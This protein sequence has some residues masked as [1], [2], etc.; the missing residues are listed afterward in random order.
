MQDIQSNWTEPSEQDVFRVGV[1]WK[2]YSRK[3]F[4]NRNA[5]FWRG[6]TGCVRLSDRF[7]LSIRCADS[8][9]LMVMMNTDGIDMRPDSI[10]SRGAC[11]GHSSS[12]HLLDTCTSG[13]PAFA[14]AL[15]T[16]YELS[17][18]CTEPGWHVQ[19]EE[20]MR[21]DG[22]SSG[23][24]IYPVGITLNAQVPR[25]SSATVTPTVA[26]L[27]SS[28][29][30]ISNQSSP[31]SV[32]SSISGTVSSSTASPSSH[33]SPSLSALALSASRSTGRT[34]FVSCSHCRLAKAK[35]D[36]SR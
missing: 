26:P 18:L 36:V 17:F 13:M 35:C 14:F 29:R 11:V 33:C 23:Y 10:R 8:E 30:A 22:L 1:R 27:S 6:Q 15:D 25:M 24:Q 34:P 16:L 21:L 7:G 4:F 3:T 32:P 9:Q 31:A 28:A 20:S 5:H 2:F 12:A 19:C